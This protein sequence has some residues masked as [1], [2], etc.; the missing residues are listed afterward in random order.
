M[1]RAC[2]LLVLFLLDSLNALGGS[3]RVI[4]DVSGK[5]Y[6]MDSDTGRV[7]S[8]MKVNDQAYWVGSDRRVYANVEFPRTEHGFDLLYLPPPRRRSTT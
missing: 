7:Y 1:K 2:L 3:L 5:V 4:H 8:E 6:T